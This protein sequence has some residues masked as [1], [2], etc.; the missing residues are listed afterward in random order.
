MNNIMRNLV[1][2]FTEKHFSASL[3]PSPS[4]AAL[5]HNAHP[6]K[7]KILK[8]KLKLV[9]NLFLESFEERLQSFYTSPAIEV[10][11]MFGSETATLILLLSG[12]ERFSNVNIYAWQ[13]KQYGGSWTKCSLQLKS[14]IVSRTSKES[15]QS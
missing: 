6:E 15:E 13:K 3:N 5:T 2:S 4:H 7:K 11:V 8:K 14:S 9:P 10:S 12:V 1:K